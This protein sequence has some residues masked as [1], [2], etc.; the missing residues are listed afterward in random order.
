MFQKA[1]QPDMKQIY[2][3][4]DHITKTREQENIDIKSFRS[5]DTRTTTSIT[6]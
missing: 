3:F 1:L 4:I 5:P 2:R 6:E